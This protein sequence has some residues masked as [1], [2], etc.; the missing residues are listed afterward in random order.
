VPG[1]PLSQNLSTEVATSFAISRERAELMQ[2]PR[3]SV[4]EK[5][6]EL[7]KQKQQLEA[8][9]LTL[10][11]SKKSAD[12]KLDTRRKIIVGTAV[13]A[14]AGLDPNFSS[15]LR[16]ILSAA[17]ERDIDRRAIADLLDSPQTS[18]PV[19]PQVTPNVERVEP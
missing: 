11:A 12:E 16:G 17:V 5:L 19:T 13:L 7:I 1:K 15:V 2:R 6:S 14:H 10:L 4:D 18:S 8:R 9:R 3:K